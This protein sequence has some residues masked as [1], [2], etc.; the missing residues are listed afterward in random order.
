METQI[1]NLQDLKTRIAFLEL[2]QLDDELVIKQKFQSIKDTLTSPLKF[3]KRIGSMVGITH[4][5]GAATHSTSSTKADWVTNFG[6]VFL[7]L[8][9]N[10]TLLRNRGIIVKSLVSILSQRTVNSMSFNKNV[11]V[12]WIDKA[13]GFINSTKKK[14]KPAKQIDYGIPP[15][16]ETY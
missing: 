3:L 13:T 8:L 16:S 15:G 12:N 1:Q 9:L 10:K 7:P 11:L 2:K 4:N 5:S 14:V 6:R